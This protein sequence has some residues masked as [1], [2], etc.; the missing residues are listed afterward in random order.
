[1]SQLTR[2]LGALLGSAFFLPSFISC[3]SKPLMEEQ[4]AP[5]GKDA[6]LDSP[7]VGSWKATVPTE[8][9]MTFGPDCSGTSVAC[10]SRFLF[11]PNLAKSGIANLQVLESDGPKGCLTKGTHRCS[12][13]V[14][15]NTVT[16]NC[17]SGSFQLTR[18]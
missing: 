18:L 13:A 10:R 5:F 16:V 6:C 17:G 11:P 8:D 4:P 3:V 9:T 15:T 14:L 1:M 2:M 12:F 7:I